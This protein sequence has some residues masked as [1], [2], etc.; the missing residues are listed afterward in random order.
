MANSAIIISSLSNDPQSP[1]N[2]QISGVVIV[3]GSGGPEL[4]QPWHTSVAFGATA[5]QINNVVTAAAVAAAGAAGFPIG[6][7][8]SK[9]IF[10][11]AV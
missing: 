6:P 3:S 1:G 9:T 5:A 8:E 2:L 10:G 7:Q 4:E 11:G